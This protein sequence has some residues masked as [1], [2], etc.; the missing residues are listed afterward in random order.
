MTDLDRRDFLKL[1]GA[2]L[3]AAVL[4][5]PDPEE[6]K[7]PAPIGLGRVT[8]YRLWAYKDPEPGA[9]R[10]YALGRDDVI[11]IYDSVK[12][13]G[14]MAHNPIWNLT[15]HGW[16]YSSWVQPVE[17]LLNGVVTHVPETGFWA[18]VSV[19]YTTLRSEPNERAPLWYRLYYSSV[20]LV[21]G[22][23][24]DDQG[25]DWYQLQDDEYPA[26]REFVRAKTLRRIKPIELRPLSPDV[27]DKRLVVSLKDQRVY[28]YE[29]NALVYSAQC[30][31]GA[32]FTI[33][34]GG[35]ADFTTPLGKHTVVRK[36]PSR[37][38]HGREGRPD[39]YDLPGVPYCTYFT[40]E[41]AAVHGAYWHNDFGHPR[42]HGCVNV[43]PHVARWVYRWT[44]PAAEYEDALFVVEEGG[45]PIVVT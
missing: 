7:K 28:A 10:E 9:A 39:F 44:R 8:E 11:D 17:N 18:Y 40:Q 29:N 14:L 35:L 27:T 45:T 38:M 31:T 2:T 24:R 25:N 13:E 42:S 19:P 16:V 33:E 15:K 4:R 43:P 21:T 37:H 41:G 6:A 20:H 26:R 12:T 23:V 1:S 32:M 34:S 5:P 36:R 22:V 3:T 30:A